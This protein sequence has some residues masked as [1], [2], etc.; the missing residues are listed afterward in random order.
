MTL[1]ELGA[2]IWFFL[3]KGE[4]PF[5]RYF[6]KK[7]KDEKSEPELMIFS[8]HHEPAPEPEEVPV[9]DEAQPEPET[10]PVQES[11]PEP[12]PPVAKPPKKKAVKPI[13]A[14]EPPR[15]MSLDR[16]DVQY[17]RRQKGSHVIVPSSGK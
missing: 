2:K 12:P 8:K 10:Q 17:V 15:Q 4:V 13:D 7:E 9:I 11:P 5:A 6:S 16:S 1:K 14:V 3:N